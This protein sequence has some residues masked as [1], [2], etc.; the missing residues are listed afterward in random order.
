MGK[1]AFFLILSLGLINITHADELKDVDQ[2]I[3]RFNDPS[4]NSRPLDNAQLN[5]LS[6]Q[7]GMAIGYKRRM[8]GNAQVFTLPQKMTHR[9]AQAIA[10]RIAAM[11]MVDYAEADA[12]MYVAATFP[13]PDDSFYTDQW[14]YQSLLTGNALGGNNYGLNLPDAWDISAG[15]SEVIVAVIDTGILPHVDIDSDVTDGS[16]KIIG[17]Y[18]FISDADSARDGD[19]R[20]SDPTDEGDWET[21]QN[22]SI[23]SFSSW[24]GTHVAGTV[25]ASSNNAQGV[26]G[27]SWNSRL[28]VARV[29]GSGGGDLSDIIDAMRWSAGLSVPGVP[30]NNHPA[31]VLN[32]SLGAN[33][34]CSTANQEAV[35]DIVATGSVIVVAA[36]NSNT[37]AFGFTPGNCNNV[38]TVA[39]TTQQG[40]RASYSNYDGATPVIDIAAP[41]GETAVATEGVLS[42]L[43]S[44]ET[45]ALN[46]NAYAWY[47]GTSMATPHV[48]GLAALLFSVNPSLTPAE[49]LTTIQNTATAFPDYLDADDCNTSLCGAGI[50][51]ATAAL[52]AIAPVGPD[53]TPDSVVFADVYTLD[54]DTVITS[55]SATLTGMDDGQSISV[56]NGSYSLNGGDFTSEIGTANKGDKLRL[57]H[58]TASAYDVSVTTE[59][60]VGSA[61]FSFTSITS[62]TAEPAS[63]ED[64]GGDSGG[65]SGGG[66][67][68]PLLVLGFAALRRRASALTR[69]ATNR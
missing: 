45:T 42:T 50:A 58:T 41:G 52:T 18:D 17:G 22:G 12:R 8:S 1:T 11:P 6:T 13:D 63:E 32:L 31:K 25:L 69:T 28:L 56:V 46:D 49:V 65:S 35:D 39:A 20:D 36:G 14:H 21:R 47:Q 61:S 51:N 15:S 9:A 4:L 2:L 37:E 7:A 64:N 24:H 26:S 33:D 16:G 54:L 66:A 30:A 60:T 67:I 55:E 44:G 5:T 29:L 53:S 3:V 27:V 38:I 43:D 23:K 59:V 10:D 57:Q 68:L 40:Q 48:A 62:E 34:D 19:G